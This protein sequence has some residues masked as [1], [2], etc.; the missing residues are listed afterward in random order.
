[1]FYDSMLLPALLSFYLSTPVSFN[2]SISPHV[3]E[4]I[5]RIRPGGLGGDEAMED[6]VTA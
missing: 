4:Q 3:N 6:E 1:M 2:L 5:G